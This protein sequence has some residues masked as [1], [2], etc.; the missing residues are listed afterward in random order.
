VP[1]A[2]PPAPPTRLVVVHGNRPE[3]LRDLLVGFMAEHPLA[4]LQQEVVLVQSNGIGQWLRL[5][6]AAPRRP[7]DGQ[8][9]GLGIAAGLEFVLPARFLW[10]AYRAVLGAGAVPE[11]S[12]F[13]REALVWRLMR[14]LPERI[15][16]PEFQPLRHFL[17]DDTD[18]R[19]R[20]QLAQRLADLFDQ[21]QVY[22]ADWLAD[23]AGGHEVLRDGRGQR[24]A[25]PPEQRWQPA[26]WRALIADVGPQAADSHRAA[27]HEAFLRRAQAPG[28][29]ARPAGLPPRVLVFGI[30]SL[31][32]QSL[33]A[34]AALSRWCEVV[35]TV[36][37]PCQHHWADIVDGRELLRA[38]RHR[39]QRRPGFPLDLGDEA[40]HLH[41]HP[42]LAS[43]GRQGRDFIDLLDRCDAQAGSAAQGRTPTWRGRRID[44]F[45]PGGRDTL[46][47]QLQDDILELRPL[48]ESTAHWP[49]V[50]P[51]RDQSIRFH[52]AHGPLREIEILHDRLL[53]LFDRHPDLQ[54]R[55]VL[56]MVPE[57]DGYAPLVE[58][59]FGLPARDDPRRIP[60]GL[61]DR[62]SR[63]VDPLA[64]ALE[65]LLALPRSRSPVSEVLDLLE[66]AA[67]RERFGLAADQL[68]TLARWIRQANIRWGLHGGQ[69]AALG[70]GEADDPAP[71][72]SWRFG[73]RRLLLGYASGEA[74]AWQGIEPCAEAAG[75]EAAALGPLV[76]L[77]E[78]LELTWTELRDPTTVEGW[79]ARFESLLAR[80]FV[81][82]NT[83][84]AMT[85]ERLRTALQDW[86][87]DA[88]EAALDDALPL[89][90]AAEHWLA[91]LD[92]PGLGQRFFAGT[93]TFATL[94]PMRS[95][96]FRVVCL[97]G[98]NDGA[99]P[100]PRT[101]ADFDLMATEHRPGDRARREDDRY[102]FLEAVLA[103]R[104]HLHVSWV[105]RSAHDDRERPPSVLVGQL[106]DH[107]AAGW[108]L[109]DARDPSAAEPAAGRSLLDALT[110][111]HPLQPFSPRYFPAAPGDPVWFTYARE[112][113]PDPAHGCAQGNSRGAAAPF[114]ADEAIAHGAQPAL[115]P[116]PERDEP[117]R[118]AELVDFLRS[119][120]RS[121]Y[122]GRLG[123]IHTERAALDDDEEPFIVEGLSRWALRTELVERQSR[124]LR[125]GSDPDAAR[126]AGLQA[127]ARRGDL[128][129]GGAGEIAREELDAPLVA[130]L[131]RERE[132]LA[133]WP[134]ND[135][136]T[137]TVRLVLDDGAT[138]VILEDA[139][140]DIR[141]STEGQAGR[142]VLESSALKPDKGPFRHDRLVGPWIHHLAAQLAAGPTHTE[143][144]WP[145]GAIRLLPLA[146]EEA[147]AHLRR[148]LA[149]WREG[150]R[151]PLPLACRTA[152]T[153]LDDPRT[154]PAHHVKVRTAYE[155]QADRRPDT[156]R[157]PPHELERDPGLRRSHP[158]YA[159]LVASG[160]FE[161]LARELLGPL[162]DA[163]KAALA[164]A[165][166]ADEAAPGA[167]EAS[168]ASAVTRPA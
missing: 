123:V 28:S 103:A 118:L 164:A 66:V 70:L 132:A 136:R 44:L 130:L 8:A 137:R 4:P 51:D 133:R 26:L 99:Y 17:A 84:D 151:R 32:E 59:V 56:V 23:W 101:P 9:P 20:F 157:A 168:P 16:R 78:A 80:W 155:G 147:G 122:R 112:W 62:A 31:P 85:L 14:L 110:Q 159:R 21:Y 148:L 60:F 149:A 58:A 40:L 89:S 154:P 131:D 139:L 153:W 2:P 100:R 48:A 72:H 38:Q 6:L 165:Q 119:P 128:P 135:T 27:V 86:L 76:R 113:R 96:P 7:G 67:V 152:I 52:V 77:V 63:G 34:L 160:E 73:L 150:M 109:A 141:R 105:G 5:A 13:D 145:E 102:L 107:L 45:E 25:L 108:R 92:R 65:H 163:V 93:V 69:R 30:S 82:A 156:D 12:P 95:I 64:R 134:H 106:R 166:A 35:L 81:P 91:Q 24:V 49:A 3:T 124:A 125:A 79:C 83:A 111:E 87:R 104:D 10:R 126:A 146:P 140:D 61:A 36:H 54:P 117:L 22:R 74:P 97:L 138:R 41:A 29:D 15:D 162:V 120:V 114:A 90:V 18:L 46:L 50:D 121:F 39:Q 98:M 129:A 53:D 11:R 47:L 55:D 161:T 1:I 42:L 37:N 71:P 43:W 116:L 94:M 57:I 143:V 158:T 19:R 127:C 167:D 68:P 144:L 33:Q 142:I 75:L 115:M 88:A